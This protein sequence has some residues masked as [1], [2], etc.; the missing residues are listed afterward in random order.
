LKFKEK[1]KQKKKKEIYYYNRKELMRS[2]ERLAMKTEERNL[3][4]ILLRE[5]QAY[6]EHHKEIQLKLTIIHRVRFQ[7]IKCIHIRIVMIKKNI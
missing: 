5:N 4:M 1:F 7:D 2:K 6:Q 3:E